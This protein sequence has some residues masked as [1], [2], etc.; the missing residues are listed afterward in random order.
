MI[1]RALILWL[2]CVAA[3]ASGCRGRASDSPAI[4][5]V[6]GERISLNEFN[7]F[8][9]L[10]LGEF[11]EQAPDALR[12]DML[13][14]YIRRRVLVVAATRAGVAVSDAE[15]EQ[16]VQDNP[17][18][19]SSA[20]AA[21]TRRELARDLLIEKYYKQ[22]IRDSRVSAEEVQQYIEQN[23]DRLTDRPGFFVREIRT[24][25]KEEADRLRYEVTEGGKDFASIARMHSDAPNAEGGGLSRYDEDQ[26]PDLL[27]KAIAPL[28]PGDI[29]PVI[30]SNYGYHIFKLER[31]VQPVP[32]EERRSQLDDR[33]D[34][35]AEELI[36]RKNQQAIDTAVEAL[37]AKAAIHIEPSALG[38]TYSG[39]LGHNSGSGTGSE[40]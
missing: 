9:T 21:D 1:K 5:T 39:K 30:H 14:E 15:V 32:I 25:S 7:R 23:Q 16:A 34:T 12:S 37:L 19:K 10:K 13:D 11:A 38:F 35:L 18:L 24:Q 28:R 36:S 29:S 17:H 31:R 27:E 22:L 3:T 26:L 6:D 40:K 4:A 8:L 20:A 2:I 33:R